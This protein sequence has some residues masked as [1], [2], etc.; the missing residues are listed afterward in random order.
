MDVKLVE[1]A[2]WKSSKKMTI[3]K[4]STKVDEGNRQFPKMIYAQCL[5]QQKDKAKSRDIGKKGPTLSKAKDYPRNSSRELTKVPSPKV[6]GVPGYNEN[7]GFHQIQIGDKGRIHPQ[8]ESSIG[9]SNVSSSMFNFGNDSGE[10]DSDYSNGLEEGEIQTSFESVNGINYLDNLCIS[11][12]FVKV[13]RTNNSANNSA[14][15]NHKCGKQ[16]EEHEGNQASGSYTSL[17]RVPTSN[18]WVVQETAQFKSPCASKNKAHSTN[19]KRGMD[20]QESHGL[21]VTASPNKS[22]K[23]PGEV[24]VEP[25]KLVTGTKHERRRKTLL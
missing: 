1:E 24:R 3:S 20:N 19:D 21:Q 6:L 14:L 23:T 16:R 10:V 22:P 11:K 13:C 25:M 8:V 7:S 4:D 5:L 17:S 9:K 12:T 18:D 15:S 2:R